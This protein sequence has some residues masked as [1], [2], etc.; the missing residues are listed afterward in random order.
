MAGEVLPYIVV[1]SLIFPLAQVYS[2]KVCSLSG[3]A[4][5]VLERLLTA[6][7]RG[8]DLLR[9]MKAELAGSLG[10]MSQPAMIMV[11]CS[12]LTAK[13][14]TN[15]R[16]VDVGVSALFPRPFV[17]TRVPRELTC[18]DGPRSVGESGDDFAQKTTGLAKRTRAERASRARAVASVLVTGCK[19][20]VNNR[21]EQL[22]WRQV[23]T[24]TLALTHTCTHLP[25]KID[26][27]RTWTPKKDNTW[28]QA[29]SK[30]RCFPG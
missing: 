15:V 28:L 21:K 3:W 9:C 23:H 2:N 11:I 12:N 4:P 22:L 20:G 26:V 30:W 16:R 13:Y 14:M 18:T 25:G 7:Q 10:G 17:L 8:I 19:T 6:S 27:S 29:W 1:K 5:G 24:Q